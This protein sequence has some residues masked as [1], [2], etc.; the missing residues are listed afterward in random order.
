MP[1]I[2]PNKISILLPVVNGRVADLPSREFHISAEARKRYGCS[3]GLFS[4]SGNV[5]LADVAAVRSLAHN[6]RNSGSDISDGEL[7]AM[8]LIDELMHYVISQY[9][10]Q[11]SPR[12]MALAD[13]ELRKELGSGEY[14]GVLN[15]FIR[16]FPP[17]L[18]H[19]HQIIAS[20]YLKSKT[21]GVSNR[22]ISLE[23]MLL[24]WVANQNPAQARFQVLFGDRALSEGTKYTQAMELL[25]R[26]FAGQPGFGLSG[27]SL[28]DLL[29]APARAHPHSLYDQ[30]QYI[31]THWLSLLPGDIYDRLFRSLLLALDIIREERRM[32]GGGPGPSPVFDFSALGRRRRRGPDHEPEAFSPDLDWMPEVVMMAK[33]TPVWL[34]QLS[35][36]YQRDIRRLD[37]IPEEELE[38]LAARGFNALWLIGVWERSSASQKI[39][40]RCGNPEALPSAYAL[41]DYDIAGNL[42][43]EAAYWNLKTRAASRGVRIAV[44]MVPNHTGIHSRWVTEHPEW[45]IQN[46]Q[47]P[48]P[49]YSFT[50][51]DL[52]EQPEIMI[53]IEDGY[54]NRSD[55]A[56]VFKRTDKKSGEARYIYHG[57]DGTHMPWNDTAQ[58]NFLL[59]EVRRAV[60]G[61]ILKVARYSSIIRFDAA[62]TLAKRHYQRLW[63]PE[64]GSGGDIPSRSARGLSREEFDRAFPTEFWREAVDTVARECPQTLLLAEAFWL[65]EGY[66]VR[67][68]GMHRVYNSAFMNMLKKEENGNFLQT[69]KNMLEFNPEIL[70]RF[71][72]FMN[73]PDEEPAAAQFGKGDKYFGVC[74]M[75]ATLPGLPMFGHGQIEGFSEKYGMEYA[76]AYWNETPDQQLITR[77]QREIF[78]LL[79]M[80][81]LF[82][83][84]EN[85]VLF[86]TS[87]GR[88][89]KLQDVFVYCNGAGGQKALFA[90]NNRCQ[91][92]EGWIKQSVPQRKNESDKTPAV[93]LLSEALDLGGDGHY[94]FR[95]QLTGLEYLRPAAELME[96]G[97][98]LQLNGY[99]YNLFTGFERKEGEDWERLYRK[100]GGRGVS[101]INEAR[102][103]LKLEKPLEALAAL[104]AP[105]E[106]LD[107]PAPGPRAGETAVRL[108]PAYQE[109]LQRYFDAAGP[110]PAN[111]AMDGPA[112]SELAR[113]MRLML[114][115]S[116]GFQSRTKQGRREQRMNA[117][118]PADC[119]DF[120]LARPEG[121]KYLYALTVFRHAASIFGDP[122]IKRI[123]SARMETALVNGGIS[124]DMAGEMRRLWEVIADKNIFQQALSGGKDD[125]TRFLN[126]E[127]VRTFLQCNWHN[128]ILWFRRESLG[129]LLYWL[130]ATS[131]ISPRGFRNGR[132][133]VRAVQ[134]AERLARASEDSGY[135][136]Q[137]ML[138]ML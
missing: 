88:G 36:K 34:D 49:A 99:Q 65:M 104:T 132:R 12:A 50:G 19:R 95:E 45:F 126:R 118:I 58:L 98:Y 137:R 115:K 82:S 21:A 17:L 78:P 111:I 122:A 3:Q 62:M 9:Q 68:L 90:Y 60:L 38:T 2:I 56:V 131:L 80:R 112:V 71:V 47:P 26:H 100:I 92:A 51:P 43:G 30:L 76:R 105:L 96:K 81:H 14:C 77:H 123:I 127:D 25:R 5:V 102:L 37:Q 55:A 103:E 91:R 79:G 117:A 18:V 15:A 28:I 57:N 116:L 54:W 1:E 94:I 40:Q 35:Q 33:N 89:Q 23:E 106:T 134:T 69:L 6:L 67:S 108:V 46:G 87:S 120:D 130:A 66:F 128:G 73:N 31:K 70:K 121:R 133:L 119:L 4:L 107:F 136:F 42:G 27:Q 64:P 84:V 22:E 41:Y 11:R 63:F 8:G 44:D 74:A 10:A 129:T 138:E 59:P 101:D 61:Q 20:E 97:F 75:M 32:R 24:L 93:R 125:L 7:Q 53:Q 16:E 110:V 29:L 124:R 72:N 86:D 83:G 135:R 39:K 48:F 109:Q 52:S 85:F 113:E 114:E 13:G